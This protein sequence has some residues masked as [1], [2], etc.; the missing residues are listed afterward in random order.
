MQQN[1]RTGF[2]WNAQRGRGNTSDFFGIHNGGMNVGDLFGGLFGGNTRREPPAKRS[3]EH[4][5]EVTLEE[6]YQGTT[7]VL[8]LSRPNGTQ[9]RLEVTVPIAPP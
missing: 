7:R 9:R 5:I 2:T 8:N 1:Q 4:A 3:I 6:A